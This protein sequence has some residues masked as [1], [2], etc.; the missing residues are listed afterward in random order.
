MQNFLFYEYNWSPN[1]KKYDYCFPSSK[2]CLFLFSLFF[3]FKIFGTCL[4]K[5]QDFH[6]SR[7][8]TFL[9]FQQDTSVVSLVGCKIYGKFTDSN[10]NN[11]LQDWANGKGGL[12]NPAKLTM[13]RETEQ[14][15]WKLNI[16]GCSLG[17]LGPSMT[18]GLVKDR[19]YPSW[20]II[21]GILIGQKYYPEKTAQ[22]LLNSLLGCLMGEGG[23][24]N[25]L[26]C[27]TERTIWRCIPVS[28]VLFK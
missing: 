9:Q 13:S 10:I 1:P 23:L 2:F 6:K 12:S 5:T 11:I 3:P 4:D 17:N 15:V 24:R 28:L 21:L 7:V 27:L 14:G 26:S 20:G 19:K 18:V 16:A 25:A 22:G 8:L